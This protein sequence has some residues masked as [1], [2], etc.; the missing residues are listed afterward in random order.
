[1]IYYD[2]KLK[3]YHE[4]KDGKATVT[5]AD[6]NITEVIIPCEINNIPIV[7]IKKKAF[8]GC[9]QLRSISLPETVKNVGEW[10]FAFCDS[11][12]EVKLASNRAVFGQGA[13]KNDARLEKLW[14]EGRS[15]ASARM[16]AAAVTVMDAEYLLDTGEAGSSEW[17]RKWDQKLENILNLADDE[18]YH[19]YVLCGEEDL[20]FDYDEYLEYNRRK[21]AGLSMLRLLY[22]EE[23][24]E[25]LR[26]RLIDYIREHSVGKES[27]AAWSCIVDRHGDDIAYYEL[28][29]RLSGIDE[30]NLEKALNSL[31]DRHAE[32]KS[33]LINH[34]NKGN[35]TDEFFDSLMI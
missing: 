34:F 8:L 35:K 2:E 5:D 17:I 31:S 15:E 7:N 11:L 4:E 33:F 24:K 6:K 27:E 14:I 18:G 16:L 20:H 30:D 25:P 22:D 12:S 23:L 26:E 3:I 1:M 21:K 19:L 9:K 29:T 13:F 28:M 10:A 32:A